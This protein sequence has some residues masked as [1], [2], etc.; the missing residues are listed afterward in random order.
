MAKHVQIKGL[1]ELLRKV[2]NLEK[3]VQDEVQL[4]VEIAA[5]RMDELAKQNIR[6]QNIIG[7]TSDVLKGQAVIKVADGEYRVVNNTYYSVFQEFGTG[8]RVQVPPGW[9]DVAIVWKDYQRGNFAQFVDKMQ[10]WCKVKGIEPGNAYIIAVSILH[11]GIKARP[12]FIPAF[13]VI[14]VELPKRIKEIINDA[15][16]S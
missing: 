1:D 5:F 9:E 14:E 12:F 13:D 2:Q 7:V 8:A 16:K 3:A 10:E 6:S 15:L 11:N 4:E